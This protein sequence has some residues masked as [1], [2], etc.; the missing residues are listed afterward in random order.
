MTLICPV[1]IYKKLYKK[2]NTHH[3]HVHRAFT[4]LDYILDHKTNFIKFKNIVVIIS[5]GSDHSKTKHQPMDI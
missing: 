4:K 5:M 3:F 1:D 2:Q